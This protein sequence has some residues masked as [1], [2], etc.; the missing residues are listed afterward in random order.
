MDRTPAIVCL[1]MYAAET[2]PKEVAWD[3]VSP[4]GSCIGVCH[5][6]NGREMAKWLPKVRM[7]TDRHMDWIIGETEALEDWCVRRQKSTKRNPVV[8]L[9]LECREDEDGVFNGAW[10]MARWSKLNP[11]P[12]L[13]RFA[14]Y[15]ACG[16]FGY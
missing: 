11:K 2:L 3:D 12:T 10:Y 7:M 5:S 9:R 4:D 8:Y 13:K 6:N 15:K 14:T 16:D 1:D